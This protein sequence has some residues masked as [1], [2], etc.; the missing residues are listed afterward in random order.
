M[1]A[2]QRSAASERESRLLVST[3]APETA[4]RIR[5]VARRHGLDAQT[6][7]E[8]AR[9]EEQLESEP[10]AVLLLDLRFGGPH[11][12]G[13]LSAIRCDPRFAS[14]PVIALVGDKD[15]AAARDAVSAGANDFLRDARI[16]SELPL[17]VVLVQRRR[18]DALS[19]RREESAAKNAMIVELAGTAAHELNQPLTVVLGYAQLLAKK[20]EEE[21]PMAK[22]LGL[23]RKE[24]ERMAEIVK[25]LG[26]ITRYETTEY[27]EGAK[28]IDLDRSSF[29]ES[30]SP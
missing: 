12:A 11:G 25:K 10:E 20:V 29:R 23:L 30:G 16:E 26:Q 1:N 24:A 13:S 17:K 19:L 9:I 22:Q 21:S 6:L 5:S 18:A 3:H 28:I 7:P 15:D 14:V 2:P 27:V 4:S 8:G